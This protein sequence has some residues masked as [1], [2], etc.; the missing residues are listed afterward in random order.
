MSVDTG[1]TNRTLAGS[2]Q[3]TDA[4]GGVDT[5]EDRFDPQRAND[6]EDGGSEGWS[7]WSQSRMPGRDRLSW[8]CDRCTRRIVGT[9]AGFAVIDLRET[10]AAAQGLLRHEG[11]AVKARW[12][13]LHVKCAPEVVKPLNPYFRIWTDRVR[14][15]DDLLDAIAELSRL[16]WFG[17]SDWGRSLVR[18]VLADTGKTSED[19]VALRGQRAQRKRR[20][21]IDPERQCRAIT[22]AGRKCTQAAVDDGMCGFHSGRRKV[23]HNNHEA[24]SDHD[25][26]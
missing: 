13:T 20:K 2:G 9:G 7:V 23:G 25:S 16:P 26:Y 8:V 6:L 17:W 14:S 11:R 4:L 5:S 22:T 3:S 12:R 19:S 10:D 1:T 18:K 15:T 24:R 21:S